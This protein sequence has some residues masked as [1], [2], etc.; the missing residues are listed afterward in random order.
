MK[1]LI[2]A[3]F[4]GFSCTP[5]LAQRYL[6]H[7]HI[8][9][10]VGQAMTKFAFIDSDG[11]KADD[12]KFI[13]RNSVNLNY[14]YSIK[15]QHLLRAEIGYRGAG[16]RANYFDLDTKWKLNYADFGVAYMFNIL[17]SDKLLLAP[18]IAINASYLLSGEQ[19][20]GPHKFD[21]REL[22]SFKTLD[23]NAYAVTHFRAMLTR[24]LWFSFEHRFGYGLF[25]IENDITDQTTKN[26]SHS[27]LLGIGLQF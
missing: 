19:N 2:L 21:V 24:D 13:A 11:N 10:S 12:L 27:A 23:V 14:S 20:I 16:S 17:S 5:L 22:K 4:V 3:L 1:K 18:G 6:S 9:F 8:G 15:N 25:N 7:S 26:L